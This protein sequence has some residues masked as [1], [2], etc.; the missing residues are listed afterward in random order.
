M[1]TNIWEASEE[2]MRSSFDV[3]DFVEEE[4]NTRYRSSSSDRLQSPSHVISSPTTFL[5]QI[6]CVVVREILH[7]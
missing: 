4:E 6:E 7:L 2:T 3:H 1:K 5:S